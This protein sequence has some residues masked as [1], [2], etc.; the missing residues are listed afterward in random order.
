ME[1][2]NGDSVWW[3][4]LYVG[5]KIPGRRHCRDGS[6]CQGQGGPEPQLRSRCTTFV[7]E[8]GCCF[9]QVGG[10]WPS[11]L[12][13]H[14]ISRPSHALSPICWCFSAAPQAGPQ[15]WTVLSGC[16]PVTT[17]SGASQGPQI[18]R[19]PREHHLLLRRPSLPGPHLGV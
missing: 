10:G 9:P 18:H 8:P 2:G 5:H 16:P 6:G 11:H 4:V 1:S 15:A 7:T 19:A 17:P 12:A 13:L 3:G 14:A